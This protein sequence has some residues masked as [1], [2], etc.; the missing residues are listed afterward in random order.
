MVSV[1]VWLQG[2]SPSSD[3]TGKRRQFSG[4]SRARRREEQEETEERTE[5]RQDAA[6]R[7]GTVKINLHW[8]EANFFSLIFVAAQREH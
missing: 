8:V 2:F 6:S 4:V 1:I 3:V 5:G 7:K